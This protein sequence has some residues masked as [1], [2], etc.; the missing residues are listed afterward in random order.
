MRASLRQLTSPRQVVKVAAPLTVSVAAIA[1]LGHTIDFAGVMQRMTLHAA[2]ILVPAILAFCAVSLF[3]ESMSLV[4]LAPPAIRD[5]FHIG[6]AARIKAA[7]YLL[8]LIHYALGAGTLSLLLRRRARIGFADAAG[9]VILIMMFDLGMV[10]LL[11]AVGVSLIATGAPELQFGMVLVVIA[12]LVTG[13]AAL[14]LPISLGPL[15]R[16]RDLELF[17]AART[18]PPRLLL[19]LAF[20]RLTFVMSF[21]LM[22]WAALTAF[23]VMVPFGA[24]LVNFSLVA[25][26]GTL[27]AVAGIGPSQVGMVEFFRNYGDRES[28]LASSIALSAGLIVF[29]AAIGMLFAREFTREALS[30]SQ[31]APLGAEEDA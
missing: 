2:A 16:I 30:A 20:L 23:G 19:E 24:L 17:R 22:G 6:T 18:T 26:A 11:V 12:I 13:L 21:E 8:S 29:R 31:S 1:Y 28:L 10:L 5:D 9:M 3:I 27:P 4:R 25:L 7:S 14:R 15:D